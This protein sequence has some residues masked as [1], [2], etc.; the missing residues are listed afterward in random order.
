MLL[1]TL[2]I[3]LA[4]GVS[5]GWMVARAVKA[6]HMLQLDN[7]ANDH[8]GQW[9][10]AHPSRRLIEP[11]LALCSVV[12]IAASIF[13]PPLGV[14]AAVLLA[15]WAVCAAALLV[16]TVVKA[17]PA[18]KPLVYTSRAIRILTTAV[19]LALLL[20]GV[21]TWF[22]LSSLQGE[23]SAPLAQRTAL[24][25]LLA[26]LLT[27]QL[28]PLILFLANLLLVPVQSAINWTYLRQ[29]RRRL[30]DVQPLVVG[31]TGSYGKTSTKYLLEQLLSGHRR[32][33][34]TPLSYNTLMGVCRA[35]NDGLPADCEVLIAEMGAYRPGDIK[36]LCDFVHPTIGILTAIGPQH[37]ERFKTI[38]SIQK[39]KYELIEALPSSGVAILN[40]DDPRCRGL[41]DRTTHVRVMRYGLDTE[42]Q[43]LDVWAEQMAV[44]PAGL[45]FTLADRQGRRV[46]VQTVLLGRHTVLNILGATCAAV[47]LGLSLEDLAQAI[48]QLPPVPHRLQLIDNGG[49][50]TVIDDSYNSNPIGATAALEVLGSFR[51]GQ[52]ILVTPG[53]VELGLLEA[54]LNEELGSQAAE[55]CDYVIL[56]GV[57][58]TKPLLAGLQRK[59]FPP[60]N[61]RV[62]RDLKAATLILPTI[63]KV[64]DTVLFENDLPDQYT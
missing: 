47:A 10:M 64:G 30:Q 63:V 49:G 35:I 1:N 61:V 58:H 60:E 53:M 59:N 20:L 3:L 41:A 4:V 7:Y 25:I 56:V 40:N 16:Y 44:G 62:V 36:E 17:E 39:T 45:S 5:L 32:V 31:I 12:F 18:K 52:R 43:S 2:I 54:Q 29:A 33:F 19:C 51:T 48:R 50:V 28:S 24:I 15:G 34:K 38:D 9:L 23:L 37:L 46:D 13:L 22:A 26:S 57:E 27:T 11:L 21:S 14:S 6:L 55:V 42:A 8:F